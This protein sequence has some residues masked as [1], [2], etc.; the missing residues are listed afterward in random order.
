MYRE[1]FG[2]NYSD[3][4]LLNVDVDV[5]IDEFK[6]YKGVLSEIK[7][8]YEA[9]IKNQQSTIAELE[10]YRRRIVLTKYEAARQLDELNYKA[11]LDTDKQK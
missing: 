5:F 1:V 11:N 8:E 4:S 6:T 9:L 2:T 7:N 10:P 3:K